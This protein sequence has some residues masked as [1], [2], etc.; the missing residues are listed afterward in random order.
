MLAG[1]NYIVCFSIFASIILAYGQSTFLLL[2]TLLYNIEIYMQYY[3]IVLNKYI[4][5]CKAVMLRNKK[6]KSHFIKILAGKS[7]P[8]YYE[9]HCFVCVI[10]IL[11]QFP[12]NR[13][14]HSLHRRYSSGEIGLKFLLSRQPLMTR[15]IELRTGNVTARVRVSASCFC[16]AGDPRA[17]PPLHNKA[18][19]TLFILFQLHLS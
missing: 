3:K 19:L 7:P 10:S 8:P 5:Y 6:I 17:A 4:C 15:S 18:N 1:S 14:Q 16:T 9:T 13:W 11:V 2:F 12:V